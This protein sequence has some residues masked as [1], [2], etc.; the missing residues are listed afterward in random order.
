MPINELEHMYREKDP[1]YIVVE[2]TEDN[3]L[4]VQEWTGGVTDGA[5]L[6]IPNGD[7]DTVVAQIGDRIVKQGGIWQAWEPGDWGEPG[8]QGALVDSF[9]KVQLD[10]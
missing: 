9:I 1:V 10:V 2:L 6:V 5:W 4:D 7:Y 8:D 3:W